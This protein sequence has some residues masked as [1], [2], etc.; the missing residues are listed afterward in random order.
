MHHIM[1]LTCEHGTSADLVE[2]RPLSGSRRQAHAPPTTLPPFPQPSEPEHQLSVPPQLESTISP[3]ASASSTPSTPPL[4]GQCSR[5]MRYTTCSRGH[6]GE[7]CLA[8]Y[9]TGIRADAG[10][11]ILL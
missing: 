5:K 6:H 11:R 2:S 9:R 3:G 7:F 4:C 10:V 8:R 1:H